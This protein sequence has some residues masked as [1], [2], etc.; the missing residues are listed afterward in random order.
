[1][2]NITFF[3]ELLK[4]DKS[5]TVHQRNLQLL[6]TEIFKTKKRLNPEIMENIFNFIEP[7]YRLWSNN[8]LERRNVKSLRYGTETISHEGPKI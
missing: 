7:A 2:E 8:C 3:E 4:K 6:A 1:M 5:V